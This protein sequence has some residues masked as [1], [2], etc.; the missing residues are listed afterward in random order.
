MKIIK[1]NKNELKFK[2]I[3]AKKKNDKTFVYSIH[4]H[5]V[6]SIFVFIIIKRCTNG[7][8]PICPTVDTHTEH[9]VQICTNLN[10]QQNRIQRLIFVLMN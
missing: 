2:Y 4:S 9:N 5:F 3:W 8:T 10:A 1:R 7:R 6:P